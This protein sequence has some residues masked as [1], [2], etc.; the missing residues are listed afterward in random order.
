MKV[1]IRLFLHFCYESHMWKWPVGVLYQM[2]I[3]LVTDEACYERQNGILCSS[4]YE[5][6]HGKP[7]ICICENKDADQLRSNCEAD[8]RLCFRYMDSAIPVLLMLKNFKLLACS[9]DCT[10]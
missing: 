1:T 4:I 5:P 9:C 10:G 2:F 3:L 6:P 8:Q 7:T